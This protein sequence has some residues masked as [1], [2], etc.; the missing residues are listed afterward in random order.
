MIWRGLVN[1]LCSV[2]RSECQ[3]TLYGQLTRFEAD[4]TVATMGVEVSLLAAFVAGL[5]SVSSPCVLPLVP[6]Y[7]AHLA[8][9]ST[10]VSG[11]ERHRL[12]ANAL[13]YVA[14]FSLVFITLGI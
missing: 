9:S 12:V 5:L 6:I 1:N 2:T 4:G 10:S 13:A 14:G 7:L 11:V 3:L 8:G